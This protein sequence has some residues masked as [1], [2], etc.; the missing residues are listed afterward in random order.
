M[1]FWIDGK[2]EYGAECLTFTS[3]KRHIYV[4]DSGLA[5]DKVFSVSLI[6]GHT[7]LVVHQKQKDQV[8]ETPGAT[9]IRLLSGGPIIKVS[10]MSKHV[11]RSIN[12]RGIILDRYRHA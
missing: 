5:Y 9:P 11:L 8:K 2:I 7:D 6:D 1:T 4:N 3:N 10:L 12:A